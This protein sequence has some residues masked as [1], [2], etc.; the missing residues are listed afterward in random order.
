MPKIAISY[1]RADSQDVTGRIFD[2]LVQHFGKQSIFFDIATMRLGFDFR[3]QIEETL[4]RSDVLLAVVGPE[5]L[6]SVE[7]AEA[8]I[9]DEADFVRIEVSTALK[10]E[11]P[12]IPVLVGGTKMPSTAQLPEELQS[13]VF[14]HAIV[15]DSGRD[16]GH[17]VDE[18]IRALDDLLNLPSSPAPN[19][20]SAQ[21]EAVASDG[22]RRIVPPAQNTS[23][24]WEA[25]FLK[26][27]TDNFS[28]QFWKLNEYH[29]LEAS[30][31]WFG[32]NLELDGERIEKFSGGRNTINFKVAS[33]QN[34]FQL[35]FRR[36]FFDRLVEIELW[37]D[38]R[39][40]LSAE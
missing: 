12:V 36:T 13:F 17:H 26:R 15:V 6:G 39:Q 24:Q 34:Q 40:L 7:G 23:G 37:V 2:R 25:Q 8:R 33:R 19:E 5:W 9:N 32:W 30:P 28:I 11:I 27:D 29:R 14:R 22:E 35:R 10:R 38:N 16:F 1:R 18:L 4:Q 21:P 31:G 20:S 3:K